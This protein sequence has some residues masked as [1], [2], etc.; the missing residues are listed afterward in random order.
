M[1]GSARIRITKVTDGSDLVQ[2]LVTPMNNLS[3]N[4]AVRMRRL[5][6]KRTYRLR[7][8]IEAV[9]ATV[10]GATVTASVKFGNRIVRGR[11][12]G[13]HFMVERG[14]SRMRAQPYARP[15]L[16]QSKNLDLSVRISS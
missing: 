7:D 5:V 6:P 3:G 9:P 14:T 1:A 13:Y 4:I 2:Q 12:V 16:Y 11:Y 8:T 15:A 10:D